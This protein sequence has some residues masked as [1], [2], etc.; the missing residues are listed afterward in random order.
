MYS[1][2]ILDLVIAK[3]NDDAVCGVEASDCSGEAGLKAL[4]LG[5]SNDNFWVSHTNSKIKKN[6]F[7][8]FESLWVTVLYT[9]RKLRN[10]DCNYNKT[11]I[12]ENKRV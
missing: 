5:S 12:A 10:T 6:F 9:V 8:W 4:N 11:R 2:S 3:S 7:C 1:L